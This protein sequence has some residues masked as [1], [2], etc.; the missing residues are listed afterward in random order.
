[1][2]TASNLG[3]AIA[4][5]FRAGTVH[6]LG[7]GLLVAEIQQSSDVTYRLFDWNRL[8]PDGKPRPLHV[9][10]ALDVVDFQRGPVDPQ[11]PRPTER[12]G[13]SRLVQ[14]DKFILDRWE[15]DRTGTIGG[16]QRFHILCVLEGALRIAGDPLDASLAVGGTALLP[17]ALGPLELTPQG[18]AVWLDAYLP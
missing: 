8:G 14:C 3:R 17:A 12:P 5:L 15:L 1:M 4:C 13:V 18:K 9:R 7:K 2:C 16:D 11:L 6:A 10:E